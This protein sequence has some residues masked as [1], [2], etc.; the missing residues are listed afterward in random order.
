[1]PDVDYYQECAQINNPSPANGAHIRTL[2]WKH[3]MRQDFRAN[4]R[5][6]VITRETPMTP[7][8]PPG[9]E[10]P[11]PDAKNQ[12]LYERYRERARAMPG[13][14]VCGRLGDYRY[15]DMDQAIGRAMKLAN[16]ILD[17]GK[18]RLRPSD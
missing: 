1:M 4:I 11:F 17:D 8:S 6:T 13:L 7:T 15:Y 2:E 9:Y 12:R 5:G 14:L 18:D 3:M 10:Y 16:R